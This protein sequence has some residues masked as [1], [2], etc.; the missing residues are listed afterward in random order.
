MFKIPVGGGEVRISASTIAG[1]SGARAAEHVGVFL[2]T[3]DLRGHLTPGE[4]RA[5]AAALVAC[6]GEVDL[7]DSLARN[8]AGRT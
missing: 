5:L 7:Y 4:A 6:A 3:A 8:F 2:Q 1:C